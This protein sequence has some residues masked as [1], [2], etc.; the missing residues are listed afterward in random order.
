MIERSEIQV[1]TLVRLPITINKE[2]NCFVCD[3]KDYPATLHNS[4]VYKKYLSGLNV[5][6]QLSTVILDI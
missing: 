2:K 3:G 5:S 6:D 1:D 4:R